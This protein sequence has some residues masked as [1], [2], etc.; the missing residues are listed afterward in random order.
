MD[1]LDWS[2]QNNL[3]IALGSTVY[4]YS[5]LSGAISELCRAEDRTVHQTALQWSLDGAC[6]AVGYSD[7]EVQVQ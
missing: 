3:A 1:V 6:M 2:S 4:V 7:G 5:V